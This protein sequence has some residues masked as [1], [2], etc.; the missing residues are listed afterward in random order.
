MIRYFRLLPFRECEC[1]CIFQA[2]CGICDCAHSCR[3]RLHI[4]SAIQVTHKY[5]WSSTIVTVGGSC[6][7]NERTNGVI[8]SSS[9]DF[10]RGVST[11][12]HTHT[13]MHAHASF[14]ESMS[15]CVSFPIHGCVVDSSCPFPHH[16][17]SSMIVLHFTRQH[18]CE[19]VW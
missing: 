4:S 2:D 12:T 10:V 7:C 8:H 5:I 17:S 15:M 9:F 11:H 13:H 3:Y 18:R 1:T 6:A 14:E 16:R 19:C